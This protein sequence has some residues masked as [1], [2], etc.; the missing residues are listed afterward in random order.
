[1]LFRINFV[2]R[3]QNKTVHN[4]TWITRSLKMI[5]RLALVVKMY[6]LKPDN[7]KKYSKQNTGN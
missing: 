7:D 1:M 6:I 4:K 2:Y 3:V 5:I